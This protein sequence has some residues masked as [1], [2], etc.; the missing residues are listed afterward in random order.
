MR[1]PVFPSLLAMLAAC[2]QQ[3]QPPPPATTAVVA[4]LEAGDEVLLLPSS[5]MVKTQQRTREQISRVSRIAGISRR[6]D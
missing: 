1:T 2:T 5:G 3:V 4:G 6:S